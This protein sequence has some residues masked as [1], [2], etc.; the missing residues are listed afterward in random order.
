MFTKNNV[1][2]CNLCFHVVLVGEDASWC[3]RQTIDVAA[4]GGNSDEVDVKRVKLDVDAAAVGAGDVTAAAAGYSSVTQH[5][6]ELCF[7]AAAKTEPQLDASISHSQ[8]KPRP[9]FLLT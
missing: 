4:R 3:I 7:G 8:C 5:V 1:Y 2:Q 9:M 6:D